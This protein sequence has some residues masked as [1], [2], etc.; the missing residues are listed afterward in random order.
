VCTIVAEIVCTIIQPSSHTAQLFEQKFYGLFEHMS[1]AFSLKA[2][3]AGLN[4]L[5]KSVLPCR[6]KTTTLKLL[7]YG[8]Y[9]KTETIVHL[10]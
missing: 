7:V 3:E 1:L 2:S 4:C 9:I 5:D 6:D 8:L 10:E